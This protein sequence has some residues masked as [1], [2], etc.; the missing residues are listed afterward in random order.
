MVPFPRPPFPR[1]N[2]YPEILVLCAEPDARNDGCD[3]DDD[4]RDDLHDS[5]H[6]PRA[7][8]PAEDCTTA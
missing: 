7:S 5:K 3:R 2:L 6:L 8:A 1:P 4:D